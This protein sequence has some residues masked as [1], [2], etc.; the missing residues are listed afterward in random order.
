M[1]WT[2][3]VDIG[4]PARVVV[5]N[6]GGAGGIKQHRCNK[7]APAQRVA[8]CSKR[9]GAVTRNDKV[10][11]VQSNGAGTTRQRWHKEWPSVARG[12]VP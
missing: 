1:S 3:G 2:E 5:V 6:K 9:G 11:P 4:I 8:G 10:V 7:M 12:T